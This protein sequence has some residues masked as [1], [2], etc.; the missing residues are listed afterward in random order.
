MIGVRLSNRVFLFG[1]ADYEVDAWGFADVEAAV[2]AVPLWIKS[3]GWSGPSVDIDSWL[4]SGH[5][6][7]G[8]LKICAHQPTSF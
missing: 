6:N 7:G 5:S 1:C 2:K 4:V 8:G 3:T